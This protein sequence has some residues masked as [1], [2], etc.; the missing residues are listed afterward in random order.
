MTSKVALAIVLATEVAHAAPRGVMI[1]TPGRATTAADVS[2]R[3]I[4]VRRCPSGGCVIRM[5][6]DDDSRTDTSSIAMGDRTI[7]SYKAGDT[8]WT[9]MMQ[10]V[11]D[12]YAPFNIMI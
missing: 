12:T 9:Q 5:G 4:F 1:P 11:R 3:I 8:I 6:T 7:G 10:C 2:S